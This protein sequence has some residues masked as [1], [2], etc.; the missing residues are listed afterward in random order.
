MAYKDAEVTKFGVVYRLVGGCKS[1]WPN[2]VTETVGGEY[3]VG[4]EETYTLQKP[5]LD[6]LRW[7]AKE[8]GRV[9]PFRIRRRP[10]QVTGTL[11]SCETQAV[12]YASDPNRYAPPSVGL[13]TQGLA[14]DVHTGWQANLDE[15]VE[16]RFKKAMKDAGWTQSRPT[17][18]PWHW[19]FGW[20]A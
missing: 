14:I 12:L 2:I 3:A 9:G 18:E 13:H 8:T 6:S 4:G 10:V 20:T 5:A 15:K 16:A 7:V 19:S 11:R 17:D 1:D